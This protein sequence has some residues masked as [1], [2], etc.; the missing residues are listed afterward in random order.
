MNCDGSV[1]PGGA[2]VGAGAVFRHNRGRFVGAVGQ[3]LSFNIP[4]RTAELFAIKIGLEFAL[5][6]GWSALV[7]ECDCLEV[8]NLLSREE[9]CMSADGVVAW[10][11]QRLLVRFQ[12]A[13]I[14][15]SPREVNRAAH[16]VA[17]HVARVE[18]RICWLGVG[19]P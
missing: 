6:K 15:F 10:E 18:R 11:V 8:V 4:P 7:V 3:R 5:E 16:M 12:H 13:R 14:V 9:E 1:F 17:Q 2:Q 19:P